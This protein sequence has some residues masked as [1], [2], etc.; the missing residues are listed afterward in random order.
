MCVFSSI[1]LAEW[2]QFGGVER[3]LEEDVLAA[4]HVQREWPA[5]WLAQTAA[6]WWVWPCVSL[7]VWG[8][9]ARAAAHHGAWNLRVTQVL[10]LPWC[11]RLRWW[12]VGLFRSSLD[13][14]RIS[15]TYSSTMA[16]FSPTG[17]SGWPSFPWKT[18]AAIAY[19]SAWMRS[20]LIER[21]EKIRKNAFDQEC[22]RRFIS[23]FISIQKAKE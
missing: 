11:S 10:E 16:L 3:V 17:K 21:G 20:L 8:E 7:A 5:W 12:R 19:G 23:D 22:I 2:L 9:A 14:S 18:A 15:S 4:V 13:C 1:L 6:E